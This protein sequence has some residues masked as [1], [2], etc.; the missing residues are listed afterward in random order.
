MLNEVREE[1]QMDYQSMSKIF[2]VLG[3]PIRLEIF[4]LLSQGPVCVGDLVRC[5]CKR[6]AYISQQLM[7]LRSQGWVE[8]KKEGWSVCYQLVEMP[9][10]R[11]LKNLIG[12]SWPKIEKKGNPLT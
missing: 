7:L 11:W 10:T 6:Q 9:E 3:N 4:T 2:R 8:A 1:A 5:T 12:R